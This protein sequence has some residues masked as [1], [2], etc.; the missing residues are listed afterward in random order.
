M[1][2]QLPQAVLD[3]GAAQ[4]LFATLSYSAGASAQ[5]ITARRQESLDWLA[6]LAPR[7]RVQSALAVRV[8]AFHHASLH[9]L[10]KT[11]EEIGEDLAL[12]HAGRAATATRM[13]DRAL[14]ALAGRQMMAPMRGLAL[15][16]GIGVE[17]AATETERPTP[18][19]QVEAAPGPAVQAT[20]GVTPPQEQAAARVAAPAAPEPAGSAAYVAK[21]LQDFEARLARGEALTGAQTE[22]LRRQYARQAE[23]AASPLAA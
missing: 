11:R 8:I 19:P 16:A 10:A 14:T 9:H 15:P 6:E 2:T 17:V 18:V 3:P 20:V 23:A 12:R 1:T 7:D 13:M 21:R 22:W 4:L 5:E